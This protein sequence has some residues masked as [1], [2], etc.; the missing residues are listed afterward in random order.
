MLRGVKLAEPAS[1]LDFWALSPDIEHLNH[2]SFGGCPLSVV[3]AATDWR[4]RLEAAPMKF[5]VLDWQRELDA[6]RSVLS[7][8]LSTP[9]DSLAFIPNATTGV[10]IALASSTVEAGDELLT[11]SHAYRACANQ[12]TRLAAVRRATIRVV[13]IELPYDADAM[14]DAVAKAITSRTRLA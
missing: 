14:V 1:P 5:F 10:A 3:D 7:E 2:G 8:F 11:T 6:S 13:P 4:E 12:L 9:A